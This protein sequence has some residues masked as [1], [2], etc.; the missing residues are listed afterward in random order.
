MSTNTFSAFKDDPTQQLARSP[1]QRLEAMRQ[2]A[3]LVQNITNYV[4]MNV[5]AN[6][7]IASGAAPAMV[8]APEEAA[9]F[10]A[11]AS[12]LTINIGTLSRDWVESM[13]TAAAAAQETRTPWVLDPVAVGVTGYR[14]E[15][16]LTLLEHRP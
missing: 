15:T 10:V 7:L 2:S 11:V 4:A 16:C 9:E 12:A 13:T 8:H 6:V 14:N 3:P 5:M 1:G